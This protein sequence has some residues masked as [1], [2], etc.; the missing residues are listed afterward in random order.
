MEWTLSIIIVSRAHRKRSWLKETSSSSWQ[1]QPCWMNLKADR[2]MGPS[3]RGVVILAPV[4]GYFR[5]KLNNKARRKRKINRW[6]VGKAVWADAIV[7]FHY[8][9]GF[10]RPT[11]LS[12]SFWVSRPHR[13]LP[14][15]KPSCIYFVVHCRA[16]SLH[17]FYLIIESTL[18]QFFDDLLIKTFV[19]FFSLL[20]MHLHIMKLLPKYIVQ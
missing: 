20:C 14:P 17:L 3:G 1:A 7:Y 11:S 2:H 8:P 5:S 12:Q 15:A 4:V 10:R 9:A 6:R 19:K 18:Q 13:I 16:K